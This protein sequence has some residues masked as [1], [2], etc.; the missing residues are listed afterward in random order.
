M[1]KKLSDFVQNALTAKK[2]RFRLVAV[3]LVLSVAVSSV[4]LFEMRQPAL[5]LA[6]DAHCGM[7]EH[8]HTDACYETVR[9]CGFSDSPATE[10]TGASEQAAPEP[11]EPE[12]AESGTV[13]PESDESEA[14]SAEIE[15]HVHTEECYR[16][17]VICGK[18]EHTHTIDCYA[19][20][21][22]D[23]ETRL[24]W[25]TMA[26]SLVRGELAADLVRI[27]ESQIGYSESERNFVVNDRGERCGYT[28]YGDWYGDPYG[29]W[30]AMFVSFCLHYAGSPTE[31][32]PYNSG[33]AAMAEAWLRAGRFADAD[34]YTPQAGD[35]IFL[36]NPE[37]TVGIV[38]DVYG[39]QLSIVQGDVQGT[40]CGT[41]CRKSLST[42]DPTIFGYGM[43]TVP[44][45]DAESAEPDTPDF[46][47]YSTT[48]TND[49]ND[50]NDTTDTTDTTDDLW[51]MPDCDCG[52]DGKDAKEHADSCAYKSQLQ[53][54]ASDKTV[55]ELAARWNEL[56]TDAQTYILLYLS[57]NNNSEKRAALV[58]L[59][60]EPG[61]DPEPD[62]PN[63]NPPTGN[64]TVNSACGTAS[65]SVTGNLPTNAQL[66]VTDPGYTQEKA[67]SYLNANLWSMIR[68][69]TVYEISLTADGVSYQPDGTVTVTVSSPDF[70]PASNELFCVAHLDAASGEILESEYVT[71][72]NGSVTF[73]AS[74]FSPYLFY[75]ILCDAE[76]GEQI[77]GTN[78][79]HLAESGFFTYWQQFMTTGSAAQRASVS[80]PVALSDPASEQ[81][82]TNKGGKTESEYGDGVEVSKTI[83]G[84]ELENVF[85]IT[86]TVTTN[87]SIVEVYKEPDMAV[88]I[89]MD[90][91]N[92]M[93]D[94]FSGVTRYAAAM[95]AAED[96]LDKFAEETNGVSK[97]GY[98]AFNTDAHQIF[99]LQKCTNE[100]EANALKNTMRT[101]TGKIINVDD[102]KVEHNRF[103]NVEAGLKMASD[104][105]DGAE[106][107]N[108]YIIFLSDG[109]PTTYISSGYN[110]YDPYDSTGRFYDHVLNKKCLYGTSYSDEA[111]IRARKMAAS[112]KAGGA[113]IFSIG[114]DVGGQTIQKY[115]TDSEKSNGFSVV[116]RT[117][118]SYEIGD[119]SS[120]EA[121]KNWLKNS[122]GSGYYYDST[123]TAGLKAAYEDIFEKI[124]EEH[125]KNAK[126]EWVAEDPIPAAHPQ[127]IEFIG[128]YNKDNTL[129][130]TD[131]P[132]DDEVAGENNATYTNTN[133]QA[134]ITWDLKDSRYTVTTESVG[135]GEKKTYFY[136]ITYR[137][138]LKNELADFVENQSYITNDP[139]TLRYRVIQRDNGQETLSEVRTLAFK[140]PA[141]K[142][143]LAELTFTKQ[144]SL[145]R[146]LAGAEFTLTHDTAHCSI[147]RGDG[148]SSVSIESVTAVSDENGTVS[149]TNIPSGHIYTLIE[150]KPPPGFVTNG[151]T[152]TVTVAYDNLTVAVSDKSAWNGIITNVPI[153]YE[154]PSTGGS[155]VLPYYIVGALWIGI[156]LALGWKFRTGRKRQNKA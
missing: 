75:R 149:F 56:P 130:F 86:L 150:T 12:A 85:D 122:I 134:M 9:I 17:Y 63:P 147:C 108:K 83:A 49:T 138:R 37:A 102:Y 79:M 70:A 54:L 29:D 100:T 153:P 57:W 34:G 76:G 5:T 95:E 142:G 80:L 64:V 33:T 91:S 19:D 135:A 109:F 127:Y 15:A 92:T 120:T 119:A 23:V 141:V 28:R 117:G 137:V 97:V 61:G 74:G 124:K 2:R 53:K 114:I 35:L 103:T 69:Y 145:G 148:K 105:L 99:G 66:S 31:D 123:N 87:D 16:T 82:V 1:P 45:S 112:I 24:D 77:R 6:G 98:V 116:D 55:E 146:P 40:V 46:G 38:C 96:F 73:T 72:E 144:D 62:T 47:T 131:L 115:V 154:L 32:T 89:V 126:A 51:V 14:E 88:V 106:N 78:W 140:I 27:A 156:P 143:Y 25:Q 81:Q 152:Y 21:S 41:V 39:T 58:A 59:V 50:T 93:K 60:G 104:M 68:W 71:V 84:T 155:G 139:T 136:S 4:V 13:E 125:E 101:A 121:Y 36:M 132:G 43:L 107:K 7:K 18:T 90:I 22:A 48:D 52:N 151:K 20:A 65:F 110:G 8:T 26:Q 3:L 11:A 42:D 94:D 118:T 44:A 10:D 111:A 67:Y 30:S 129:V 133:D 113:T 128:F